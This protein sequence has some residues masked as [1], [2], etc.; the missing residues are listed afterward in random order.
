MK[1]NVRL[2]GLHTSVGRCDQRSI[3]VIVSG[4]PV[5]GGNQMAV[6]VTMRS[7]LTRDGAPRANADWKDGVAAETARAD[8]EASYPELV[9]GTRCRLVVLALEVGGRWSEETGEFLRQLSGAKAQSVPEFARKKAALAFRLRWS[10]FLSMTAAKAFVDSLLLSDG[11][12]FV[13]APAASRPPW[14]PD[15]LA[16]IASG[17]PL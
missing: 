15:I 14:L 5:H 16:D 10:R 7:A 3:E 12:R 2:C 11:E 9:R 13:E 8:K 1:T 17:A 4:I 6:D